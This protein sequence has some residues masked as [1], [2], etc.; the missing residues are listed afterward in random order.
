MND[1]ILIS[2]KPSA[3]ET[4][5]KKYGSFMAGNAPTGITPSVHREAEN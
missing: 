4:Q 2:V 3:K 1:L 5:A